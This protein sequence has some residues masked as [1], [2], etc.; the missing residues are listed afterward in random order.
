[1][2]R[3]RRNACGVC[4]APAR[5]GTVLENFAVRVGSRWLTRFAYLPHVCPANKKEREENE[6][7]RATAGGIPIALAC[8]AF[9]EDQLPPFLWVGEHSWQ[10]A[11]MTAEHVGGEALVEWVCARCAAKASKP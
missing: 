1:M 11:A 5:P 9:V 2:A 3:R 7:W 10:S 8:R 6:A 4:G